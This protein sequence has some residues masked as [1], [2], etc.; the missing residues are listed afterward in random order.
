MSKQFGAL[1]WALVIGTLV[2]VVGLSFLFGLDNPVSWVLL[3]LV[4]AIPFIYRKVLRKD[5]VVWKDSYSVG[6][7]ALD[8]DHQK[9]IQLLN[10]FQTAYDYHTG[11]EF[12][13]KALEELVSYTKYHFKHEEELLE[14]HGY[15]DIEA[16]KEKHREMALQVESFLDDYAQQGHEALEGVA[17]Y[18]TDWLINHINGTDKEY[19]GFLN[20]K[21]IF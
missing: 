1:L 12:E 8:E 18:L 7:A 20:K 11:E 15:P 4:L 19:S 10:Q 16:H 6:I 9:L 13:S 14:E 5:G 3:A 21:G 2:V 17:R